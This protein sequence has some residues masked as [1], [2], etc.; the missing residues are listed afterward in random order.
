MP[1]PAV[2]LNLFLTVAITILGALTG[3]F[4]NVVI[5][6]VPRNESI[7]F[8][9][10]HCPNCNRKLTVPELVPVLSWVFQG[11]R[12]RGCGQRISF[13][14][15]FVELLMAAGYLLLALR[16]PVMDHGLS[17]LP[18]LALFTILV[19]LT[20]IDLDTLTLPDSLTIPALAVALAGT[21]LYEPS[22]GLPDLA[23]AATGAAIGAGVLV[24]INRI[25]GLAL[26]RFRDTAERLWPIG[27]DQVNLA[28]VV[29]L[30]LGWQAGI[31]A[32]FASLLLN[33]LTRRTIRLPEH[34][35]YMLW[36]LAFVI[37]V[38]LAPF[39]PLPL[40][41]GGSLAAAGTLAVAG[42]VYWWSAALAGR[43][44][45]EDPADPAADEP[46][47][48]G[49]GDVKLAAVLG[50]M[51][52]WE[53]FLLTLLLA[54]VFGAIFGVIGRLTGG[55][56]QIPFGPYLVAGA[57]VT[58]FFGDAIIGWYVGLLQLPPA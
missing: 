43:N 7:V 35:A 46:I 57:L 9:G 10:S 49:F 19:I 40:A 24:L 16:W 50:A 39:L 6:R 18:L 2:T 52:G 1:D 45:P 37:V 33:L 13:R 3:S 44:P 53:G 58:L 56:R 42:A 8:P 34:V 38:P 11:G 48:M 15:P 47:A 14:Y 30:L 51:L 29:G 12:C 55:D 28:A 5:W 4:A 17:V 25:G 26:R 54:V 20:F 31:I 41:I 23:A 32:G 27:F 21:F 22:S 36:L